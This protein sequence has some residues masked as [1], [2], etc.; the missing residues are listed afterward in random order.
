MVLYVASIVSCCFSHVVDGSSLCICIILHAFVVVLSIYL[1]YVSFRPSV[2]SNIFWLMFMGCVV[3][4]HYETKLI[5]K[6]KT[7]KVHNFTTVRNDKLHKVGGGLL[8]LF[9]T[10]RSVVKSVKVPVVE[11]AKRTELI[12]PDSAIDPLV[13]SQSGVWCK[14]TGVSHLV[15]K[16]HSLYRC[17]L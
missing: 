9:A 5:P 4:S 11:V 17:R 2:S 3:S 12:P 7:P 10:A 14:Q 1:L 13:T 6:V 15:V 8:L 16:L